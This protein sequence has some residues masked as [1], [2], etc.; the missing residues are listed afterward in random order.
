MN[1]LDW[2]I[3]A[4]LARHPSSGY[5]LRSWFEQHGRYLGIGASLSP[6]YRALGKLVERGL[7]EFDVEERTNAPDAK[8]YRLTPAGFDAL[9]AWA[10]EPHQPSP[11]PM[12]PNFM[13]KFTLAGQ[14]GRDIALD[15]LR[16]ELAYRLA[17]KVVEADIGLRTGPL[18]PV[19]ELR[20]DWLT[21][22]VRDAH[23]RG[24]ASTAALIAWLETT[25]DAY[26]AEEAAEAVDAAVGDTTATQAAG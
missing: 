21:R 3:L 9:L 18:D 14:F 4:N 8:V 12:D 10:R 2:M 11:R 25:I 24:Y 22:V 19:P 13:V 26:E 23:A 1:S 6:I 5:D 7:A 17:Q 20:V 16:R 15:V